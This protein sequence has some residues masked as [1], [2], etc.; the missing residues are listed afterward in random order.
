M[1][2]LRRVVQ[3]LRIAARNAE[4]KAGVSGAQLFVLTKLADAGR[5]ALSV[6]ELAERT[7]THQSSV[8]VVV[9]KLVEQGLI[10]RVLSEEDR[11]R[12]ELSLTPKARALIRKAP[13]SPQDQ[14]V[15]ALGAMDPSRRAQLAELMGELV[16]HLGGEKV[17][18]AMFFEHAAAVASDNANGN[19][20]A[21]PSAAPQTAPSP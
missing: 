6:N 10:Q 16:A 8:S 9:T 12:W 1:D 7:L 17:A 20:V 2:H 18:P 13:E 15:E 5:R 14:I 3:V 19:A 21:E 4:K 11:R